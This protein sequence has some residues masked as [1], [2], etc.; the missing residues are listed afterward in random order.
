MAW[1]AGEGDSGRS[2]TAH[3][4]PYRKRLQ[5]R[6]LTLEGMGRGSSLCRGKPWSPL[7]P[8]GAWTGRRELRLWS[9]SH[10]PLLLTLA[11]P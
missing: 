5:G 6:I 10:R 8:G 1:H 9:S 11:S 4:P 3:F 7:P 2:G